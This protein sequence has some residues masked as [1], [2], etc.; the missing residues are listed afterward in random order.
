MQTIHRIVF[1]M[2][3][4]RPQTFIR[5]PRIILLFGEEVSIIRAWVCTLS[6]LINSHLVFVPD[7]LHYYNHTLSS[8]L[9]YFL[10]YVFIYLGLIGFGSV[11]TLWLLANFFAGFVE[12]AL[13][14]SP[15]LPFHPTAGQ[16]AKLDD[17]S[18][19]L[20]ILCGELYILFTK[21]SL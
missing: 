12:A 13:S 9:S 18:K 6:F 20:F 10:G 19:N 16:L 8:L 17:W 5:N 11:F 2:L 14:A 3:G 1:A 15:S 21:L 7:V 4:T